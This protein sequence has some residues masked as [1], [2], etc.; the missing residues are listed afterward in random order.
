MTITRKYLAVGLAAALASSAVAC[1]NDGLTAVNENPNSPTDAP[2]SALFTSAARNTVATWLGNFNLRG[3]ELLA[4]HLAEVQY[5]DTD[6]YRTNRLGR[7]ASNNLFAA[8]TGELQDLE[9]IIRRGVAANDASMYGPAEVLRAWTFFNL[10]DTFGDIPYSQAFKADSGVLQPE[11]DPQAAIYADLFDRLDAAV[12]AMNGATGAGLGA[13]DP[14]YGGDL[15]LW[16]RFGNSLHA[17]QALRLVNVD[18]ATASAELQA[19]FNAPGGL[20]VEN[21]QNATL[22]WPGDGVY[23]NP[24]ASNFQTRDDHRVSDRMLGIMRA[25]DDPRVFVYAMPAERDTVEVAGKTLEYCPT[26]GEPCFMG[27]ANA[28]THA[29]AA[30][31]VPYTSRPGAVFYPGAT[32]YGNYGG[33]GR[34]FPSFLMTA[35]EVAFI[36][37]EA[38]Q[39]SLGGL[40]P[41]QA[42]GFYN[43]GV[44]LSMEQWGITSATQIAA[45]MAQPEVAYVGTQTELLSKIATQ[46]WLA[47]FSDGHQAWTEFRRTCQPAVIEPGPAALLS[48]VPRRML[49][50]STEQGVNAT[51]LAE[52]V[53]RMGGDA[54]STRMYWDTAPTAA[55]TYEAGC[56]VRE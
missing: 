1:N 9:L 41:V 51:N 37:A 54:F 50:S 52:A 2:S 23:D 25:T 33:G 27:L 30:P 28:L 19:A 36:R 15:E 7:A 3:F 10:T 55:P 49:F 44:R 22:V 21:S 40:T 13:A 43:E 6:Q 48:Y 8:Y 32:A 24:W 14:I 39:R 29:N 35:A 45:Y 38:A 26:A 53:D 18:A 4:Q 20:I 42:A 5:P 56:G 47:L 31:F 12:V 46:K 11:Y 17:R 16:Q 34:S